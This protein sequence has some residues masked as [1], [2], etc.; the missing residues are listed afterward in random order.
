[1]DK[2]PA[3]KG[4][5]YRNLDWGWYD[6]PGGEGRPLM[7]NGKQV[8]DKD[9]NTVEPKGPLEDQARAMFSALSQVVPQR[10]VT[11]GGVSVLC[12]VSDGSCVK[13]S[14]QPTF[15]AFIDKELW[16]YILDQQI[17][18]QG[19]AP[20]KLNNMRAEQFY[21]MREAAKGDKV[22]L[23]ILDSDR[24]RAQ[25]DTGAAKAQNRGAVA[26]FPNSHNL[27]LAI[28]FQMSQ[29]TQKYK[30]ETG[31]YPMSL[32]IDMRQSPVHKWLFLNAAKFGFYP[33]NWEPWHWE[34]NP[35]SDLAQKWWGQEFRDKFYSE[36]VQT[37]S[38]SI[39]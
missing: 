23:I 28:D 11:R 13:E 34:F 33:F 22:D 30:P 7:V 6:Y 20:H 26:P 35:K 4:Q 29:G 27:G 14:P 37:T 19:S 18:V 2:L 16:A 39:K 17:P 8:Q 36:Y 24:T 5:Y 15:N 32:T 3:G 12:A 21:K 10:Q 31:T 9:G 38:T 25:A 1:M